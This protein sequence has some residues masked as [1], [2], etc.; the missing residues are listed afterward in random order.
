ME[1]SAAYNPE[2]ASYWD[3]EHCGKA[4]DNHHW[5][6]CWNGAFQCQAVVLVNSTTCPS[7]EA[8]LKFTRQFAKIDGC[9]CAYFTQYVCKPLKTNGE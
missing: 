4:L 3:L 2:L 1:E 8:S 6:W 7:G 5:A 9:T